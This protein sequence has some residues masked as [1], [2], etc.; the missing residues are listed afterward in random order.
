MTNTSPFTDTLFNKTWR[1][2]NLY[3][4]RF[5]DGKEGLLKLNRTQAAINDELHKRKL[6]LKSRQQGVST[7]KVIDELD[8]CIW[9]DGYQGGIQSYGKLESKKLQA[10]ALLAWDKLDPDIKSALGITLVKS[11]ADGMEFSN[12]SVLRIGNF[13]GDTLNGLHVS[14]LAKISKKYPEKAQELKT[15]A[16]EA[17]GVNNSIS[18]ETTSEGDTGLFYEMWEAAVLREELGEELTPLDFKPMFFSYLYDVD[19][20]LE[21]YQKVSKQ[22]ITYFEWVVKASDVRITYQCC[23]GFSRGGKCEDCGTQVHDIATVGEGSKELRFTPAL[24]NWT[25]VKLRGL[26][27]DFDR[28]YPLTPEVAFAR[29]LD[30]TYFKHEYSRLKE[31][32]RIGDFPFIEGYGVNVV[33]D[34]G[35]NDEMVLLFS[36]TI[37][38]VPR[39]INEYHNTGQ[40]LAFYAG[41]MN[42]LSEELGYTYKDIVFPHDGSVYEMTSGLTRLTTMHNLGFPQTRVLEDKLAFTESINVA[43]SFLDVTRINRSTC[44]NTLSAIQ[45]YRKKF[46]TKLGMYTGADVHDIHSNYG[47]AIRYLG[48]AL[49]YSI[50]TAYVDK[51]VKSSPIQPTN[52]FGI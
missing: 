37:D 1:L 10:K 49:N 26:G 31:E 51:A 38:K 48:Q 20:R 5:K 3:T 40:S 45:Q 33:F 36:Q 39:L 18:I 15:G 30:G 41:V 21:Q 47:A 16:F 14:E 6:I 43:R 23:E 44:S 35:V 27:S 46:D 12:G 29:P 4:I 42:S 17:V 19:C 2:N 22:L 9:Q 7:Y 34:L 13:R 24:L 32:D 52:G 50:N 8:S 28:E 11:N 25:I